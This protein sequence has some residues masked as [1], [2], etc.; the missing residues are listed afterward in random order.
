MGKTSKNKELSKMKDWFDRHSI[1]ARHFDFNTVL[2]STPK[3]QSSFKNRASEIKE[4]YNYKFVFK[5]EP[6]IVDLGV[7]TIEFDRK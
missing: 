5:P 2:E 4:M 1:L 7:I 3:Q 6:R